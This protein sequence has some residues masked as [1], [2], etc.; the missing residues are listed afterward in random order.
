MANESAERRGFL[1]SSGV[2]YLWEKIRERYDSKLDRITAADDSVAVTD[3]NRI[4]LN[5]SPRPD[6]AVE[7]LSTAGEEGVYVRPT[8]VAEGDANGQIKVNGVNINVHG[9]GSA[10]YEQA[11]AFDASGSAS[12][13]YDAV[14]ALSENEIDAA[15]E[16]ANEE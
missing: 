9:L 12:A 16:A 10:A 15:I 4:G 13:V 11:G 6:N 14:Q 2:G 5:V 7:V 1:D 8:A 3:G